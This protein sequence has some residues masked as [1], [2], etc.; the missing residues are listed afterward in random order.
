M[1]YNNNKDK[2]YYFL[3]DSFDNLNK[4]NEFS[5]VL[6]AGIAKN[7]RFYLVTRSLEQLFSN[8]NKYILKLSDE[9]YTT[10]E[11]IKFNINNQETIIKNLN[12]NIDI[13]TC[14]IEY[15]TLQTNQ[16][17]TFDVKE[18]VNKKSKI[19]T[20]ENNTIE[21]LVKEIDNKLKEIDSIK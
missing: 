20:K 10:I 9:I 21:K 14:E 15:P 13:P 17:N 8:Y 4:I 3:L 5:E 16:I 6:S 19:S 1:L 2:N 7:I 12:N 18:F 11:E